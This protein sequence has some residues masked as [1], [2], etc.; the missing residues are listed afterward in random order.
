MQCSSVTCACMTYDCN[1]RHIWMSPRM[2]NSA[3]RSPDVP[4]MKY[5]TSPHKQELVLSHTA[6]IYTSF[7]DPDSEEDNPG[8][9]ILTPGLPSRWKLEDFCFSHMTSSPLPSP[10]PITIYLRSPISQGYLESRGITHTQYQLMNLRSTTRKTIGY[11]L[12][13]RWSIRGL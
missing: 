12:T 13:S 11:P 4:V 1:W 3:W 10:L 2:C 7:L 9:L 8:N 6:R 5:F